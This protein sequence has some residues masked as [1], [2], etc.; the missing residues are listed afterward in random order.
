MPRLL[1]M[2]ESKD[3]TVRYCALRTIAEVQGEEAIDVLKQMLAQDTDPQ[4]RAAA[5]FHL[6]KWFDRPDVREVI[7]QTLIFLFFVVTFHFFIYIEGA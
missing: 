4:V 7:V 1:E 2:L 5:V 3:G 6:G